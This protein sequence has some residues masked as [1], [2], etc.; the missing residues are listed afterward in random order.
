MANFKLASCTNLAC[1]PLACR[2][3]ILWH[4]ASINKYLIS[5]LNNNLIYMS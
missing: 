4:L 5:L 3:F 2:L 1:K